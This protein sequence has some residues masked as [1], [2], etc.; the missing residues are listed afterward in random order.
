MIITIIR[1][2]NKTRKWTPLLIT[3]SLTHVRVSDRNIL[4]RFVHIS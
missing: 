4:F 3:N 2:K 1:L